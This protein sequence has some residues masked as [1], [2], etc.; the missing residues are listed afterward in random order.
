MSQPTSPV[1]SDAEPIIRI[2]AVNKWFDT[3]QVLNNINL[4]VRAGSEARF[5]TALTLRRPSAIAT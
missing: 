4:T 3:F 1:A 2:E 5:A